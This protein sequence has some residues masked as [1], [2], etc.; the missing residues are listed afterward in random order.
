MIN[1]IKK[2]ETELFVASASVVL[3][4]VVV[5]GLSV[6]L[7]VCDIQAQILNVESQEAVQKAV[8]S[9]EH[10]PNGNG[11]VADAGDQQTT[12]GREVDVIHREDDALLTVF[13]DLTVCP[14]VEQTATRVV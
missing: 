10:I 9:G 7:S 8:P 2:I 4:V 13:A 1:E 5:V 6:C 12:A 3:V 14:Q 11:V